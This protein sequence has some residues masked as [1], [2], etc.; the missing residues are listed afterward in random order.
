M[1]PHGQPFPSPPTKYIFGISVKDTD[2]FRQTIANLTFCTMVI[3][4][5]GR[6]H[7]GAHAGSVASMLMAAGLCSAQNICPVQCSAYEA[8]HLFLLAGVGPGNK[9]QELFLVLHN[10]PMSQQCNYCSDNYCPT[11]ASLPGPP[12]FSAASD[13][14][15][16][17]AWEHNSNA[18]C[19]MTVA[20]MYGLWK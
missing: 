18:R 8:I 2:P 16:G 11:L 4:L 17:G 9:F 10:I 1:I 13:K 19:E 12:S 3:L 5:S 15:L 7:A 14:K 6:A 20:S